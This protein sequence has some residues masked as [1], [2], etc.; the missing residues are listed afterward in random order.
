[1]VSVQQ[2]IL[3]ILGVL[4]PPAP[5]F[6]VQR[7]VFTK[8]FLV[9]LILTVL[10][11]LPGVLFAIYFV[12]VEYK[13]PEYVPVDEEAAPRSTRPTPIVGGNRVSYTDEPPTEST[14]PS[15]LT[16]PVEGGSEAPPSYDDVVPVPVDTKDNKVQH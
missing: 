8:E 12:L 4:V 15:G 13:G 1:M 6:I 5:V 16:E 9:C 14:E 10:A 2:V 3:C 7:T 11:H